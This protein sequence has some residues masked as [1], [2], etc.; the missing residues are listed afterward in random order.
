MNNNSIVVVLDNI[1]V[2]GN[3]NRLYT[4]KELS[5]HTKIPTS[6]IASWY[7]NEKKQI[8]PRL[9]TLDKLA[10]SFHV[11]TSDLFIPNSRFD[12]PYNGKNDSITNFQ[13]NYKTICIEKSYTKVKDRITYMFGNNDDG[14][15]RYYSY[16]RKTNYRAI[17]I[18]QLDYI[19]NLLDI[20]TYKLLES[21]M[22]VHK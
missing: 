3:I 20:E 22:E 6:T 10:D 13:L 17:P 8:Y 4:Y 16:L 15:E 1:K 5:I 9:K 7:S 14:K 11:H 2:L 12:H 21:R 19:A 18:H